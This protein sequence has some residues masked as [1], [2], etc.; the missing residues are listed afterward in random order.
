MAD[1]NHR[2]LKQAELMSALG[3]GV[4][5]AG[6]GAMLANWLAA[7]A[8]AAMLIGVAVHGW[9]MF[10]KRRI[11]NMRGQPRATWESVLYW[12]CWFILAMLVGSI[13]YRGVLQF[14]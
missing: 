7:F 1:T 6:L 12:S 9:A 13:V 8:V 3:A 11:E 10:E 2:R 5:G 4:L 14:R